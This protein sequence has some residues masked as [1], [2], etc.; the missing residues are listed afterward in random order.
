MAMH[1]GPPVWI[2]FLPLAIVLIG[3]MIAA[4][5]TGKVASATL[6]SRRLDVHS[7]AD[8]QA[9]FDRILSIGGKFRVDDR[10]PST[11]IIV[12]SSPITFGTWGF[13]YPVYI[14]ADGAGSRIEVGCHSKFIQIGP[15]VTRW[16][17]QCVAA[18]EE[19]LAPPTARVA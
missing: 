2:W 7:A 13:L 15:L 14:H 18:I 4:S 8:P 3:Y 6:G 17:K 9:A 5:R 1:N 16:H 19:L 11:K 10:D 12:L